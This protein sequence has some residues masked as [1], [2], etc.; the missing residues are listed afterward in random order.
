MVTTL[1]SAVNISVT[2]LSIAIADVN[3]V[4]D[5]VRLLSVADN[6]AIATSVN[7]QADPRN[8]K[9][10]NNVLYQPPLGVFDISDP[11]LLFG[12][13]A[14]VLTP[15]QNYKTAVIESIADKKEGTD[16][17]FAIRSMKFYIAKC[18][19]P[20]MPSPDTAF[21]MMEYQL[22]T[23]Q[24][25]I[26]SGTQNFD[27]MLP[28]STQKIIIFIQNAAAGTV[29]NI[30]AT[31]LK[32]RQFSDQGGLCHDMVTLQIHGMSFYKPSK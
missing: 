32:V 12:D 1:T 26:Q 18:K 3:I 11:T 2:I 13:F 31:R 10:L 23:K 24:L 5:G 30:N 21:S 6:P 22:L 25:L 8:G 15:N 9:F 27:F 4:N 20:Q 28:P 29:S 14:I 17:K 7:N 16:Y 19:I